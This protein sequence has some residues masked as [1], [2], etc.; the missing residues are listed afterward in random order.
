MGAAILGTAVGLAGCSSSSNLVGTTPTSLGG[1]V[2]QADGSV[3]NV[4]SATVRYYTA[5][6][7]PSPVLAGSSQTIT[8]TVYNCSAS[9]AACAGKATTSTQEMKSASIVVPAGF[10]VAST[11]TTSASGGKSW[12]ATLVAGT[13]QLVSVSGENNALEA[14]ESVSVTFTADAPADCGSFEFTTVGYNGTTIGD[15]PY[16]RVGNQPSIEVNGCQ[17]AGTCTLSQGYWKTHAS[18]WPVS[19]LTLGS[20]TYSKAQ[21]LDILNQP[22]VGNGLISLAYQLI[23]AKLNIAN[24]ANGATVTTTIADA[25]ALIGAL[26]VPPVGSGSL[27]PSDTGALTTALEAFNAGVNHCGGDDSTGE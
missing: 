15:T 21:L 14:G 19:S 10:T 13:I 7:T 24:G 2:G 11:L 3:R 12:T 8:V 26:V 1:S 27:Q 25:D 23:A 17:Q 22:V 9:I 20:T 16:T 4:N 5:S 18:A 6:I